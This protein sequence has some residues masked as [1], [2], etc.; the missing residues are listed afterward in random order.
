MQAKRLNHITTTTT[1]V[2]AAPKLT[3]GD[4]NDTSERTTLRTFES[5]I[6]RALSLISPKH[7]SLPAPCHHLKLSASLPASSPPTLPPS[8][9]LILPTTSPSP[10]RR[11]LEPD[12]LAARASSQLAARA[13]SSFRRSADEWLASWRGMDGG[14]EGWMGA[15]KISARDEQDGY[16]TPQDGTSPT[17]TSGTLCRMRGLASTARRSS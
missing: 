5:P 13:V 15:W 17:T 1:T 10:A 6:L 3:S 7:N 4:L 12:R 11:S 9:T 8:C 14:M 2:I 16:T